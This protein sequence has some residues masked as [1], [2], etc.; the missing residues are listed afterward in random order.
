MKR[1]ISNLYNKYFAERVVA[2]AKVKL[3]SNLQNWTDYSSGIVNYVLRFR[4]SLTNDDLNSYG[5]K[6][7]L[8]CTDT[9]AIQTAIRWMNDV[10]QTERDSTNLLANSLD[11]Y[12]GLLYKMGRKDEALDAENEALMIVSRL[13]LMEKIDEFKLSNRQNEKKRY[14]MG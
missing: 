1:I 6:L 11:T 3:S 10:V 2:N 8:H 7:F 14:N 13:N 9:A 12:A 5:W 4:P